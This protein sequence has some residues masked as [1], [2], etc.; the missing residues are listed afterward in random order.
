MESK[1]DRFTVRKLDHAGREVLT[2]PGQV[3]R[4]D[5]HAIVLRTHWDRAPLDLGYVVLEPGDRWTEHFFADRWYN[6]FRICTGDGALKGWYCNITRPARIQEGEVTAEDLALDLWVDPSGEIWVLD[7]AEFAALPLTP[8]ERRAG[9]AALVELQ[10]LV[11]QGAD[12]F[13]GVARAERG[14]AAGREEEH[15][16]QMIEAQVGRL[17][18]AQG[19]TVAVAESCTG[20][21]VSSRITDVSGSSDYYR[22]SVVA[23]A[24]DIKE[25]LLGVDHDTLEKHG[26]VSAQTAQEMAQGVRRVIQ[27][28]LGLA[29]TGIAGPTG[30]TPQKPVGL[31]YVALIAPD[32]EWVERYVWK[33][34]RRLNKALSSEVVLD[35][36]RR[37]LE[38]EL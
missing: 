26:A 35:L 17:L 23:Y 25:A 2:Y 19:L 9:R 15:V 27:T 38:G 16:E 4:R 7:E 8:D 33:W 1:G 21:L 14:P 32:G 18:R 13:D 11:A 37:Y 5:A 34:S 24:S 31:V 10:A 30:G 6:V 29:V 28:D 20:G 22:G 3:L 36:L 12:P